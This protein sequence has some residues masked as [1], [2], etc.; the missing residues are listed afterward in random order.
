MNIND[1]VKANA[2]ALYLGTNASQQTGNAGKTGLAA[3]PGF[4][5]AEKRIQAQVDV[6]TAQLSSFG[7]L[8]SALSDVPVSY[9]HLTLPTKRIV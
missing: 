5:K 7:K 1:F 2:V 4:Q 9:T 8:K 3:Q 6:A